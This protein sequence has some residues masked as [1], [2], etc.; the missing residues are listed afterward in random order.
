MRT[1]RALVSLAHSTEGKYKAKKAADTKEND[2]TILQINSHL[3][4]SLPRGI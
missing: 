4:E 2:K 1:A 3:K